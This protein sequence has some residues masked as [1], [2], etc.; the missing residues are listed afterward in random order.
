MSVQD[1]VAFQRFNRIQQLF[2]TLNK[3]VSFDSVFKNT[4]CSTQEFLDL[5]ICYSIYS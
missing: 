5:F 1:T 4:S 3:A 2:D